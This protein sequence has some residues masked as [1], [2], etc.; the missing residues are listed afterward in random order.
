M[1]L[2][3]IH[4]LVVEDNDAHASAIKRA[5]RASGMNTEIDVVGSLREFRERV[6]RQLTDVAIMDLNLPDGRAVEALT[7][8]A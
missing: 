5:F 8:P 6:A 3:Q 1:H 7:S 4:I 2:P